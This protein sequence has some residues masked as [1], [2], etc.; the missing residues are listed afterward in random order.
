MSEKKQKE[1]LIYSI[2]K[3][4]AVKSILNVEDSINNKIEIYNC[5]KDIINK[6]IKFENIKIIFYFFVI[7]YLYNLISLIECKQR[8]IQSNDS[9]IYLKTNGSGNINIISNSYNTLPEK[10][11]INGI[12]HDTIQKSYPFENSGNNINNITLI[13]NSRFISTSYMFEGCSKIIEID[14][15]FF[16]TSNVEN[17]YYMFKDCLLLTS[18]D[19]S[20][21][22][23]SKVNAINSMFENCNSLTSLDLSNF[24]I[25]NVID[26]NRLFANCFSLISLNLSNFITFN[27]KSMMGLFMQCSSLISLDLSS[28]NTSKVEDMTGMFYD[29]SSLTS[30]DL[31]NFNTS[32]VNTM[33]SMFFGFQDVHL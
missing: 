12:N 3:F 31:S 2:I 33:F 14:F 27:V 9:T 29:C 7:V 26:M 30:L 1:E 19:F 22:N 4:K 15:T 16:D 32:N 24:N 13:W 5:V 10:I 25:I 21:F 6:K 11:L 23:T 28:F 8:K 18:L 17:M 20:N